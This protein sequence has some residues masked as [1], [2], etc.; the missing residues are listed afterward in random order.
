MEYVPGGS[1]LQLLTRFGRF[2]ESVIGN[3]CRQVLRGLQYLHEAFVI[4]R[5]IKAANILVTDTGVV[6]LSDF[7]S[8][9]SLKR[10][11]ATGPDAQASGTL[12]SGTPQWIAPEVVSHGKVS[13]ASDVW[14]FGCVVLEM[15]TAKPP[16]HEMGWDSHCAA[17]Y[18]IGRATGGPRLP[19]PPEVSQN[20]HDFIDRC[21]QVNPADRPSTGE[22]Q[23][24][25]F[26]TSREHIYRAEFLDAG[27][28]EIQVSDGPQAKRRRMMDGGC[29]PA[30]H[31]DAA[32]GVQLN[33]FDDLFLTD[34]SG[35]V[36]D[37]PPTTE[38]MAEDVAMEDSGEHVSFLRQLSERRSGTTLLGNTEPAAAPAA[39]GSPAAKKR[40]R[41]DVE[42]EDAGYAYKG[43]GLTA[44][45]GA[46]QPL[47]P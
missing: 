29:A 19:T 17:L 39:G 31:G 23:R 22:L 30:A 10:Q 24:D 46:F 9:L 3:Y 45:F 11:D 38:C 42:Q 37:P 13:F 7:G 33:T 44:A 12:I 35:P 40:S 21:L 36:T 8:A 6:K 15:C 2:H 20:L 1:L 4:H 27:G 32:G 25:T 16:W 28:G 47:K 26:L 5:D 43:T 41:G 14:S 18:Y 34:Y